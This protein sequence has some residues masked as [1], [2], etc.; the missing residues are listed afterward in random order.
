M[1]VVHFWRETF[2]FREPAVC[3]SVRH[4]HD[5]VPFQSV[6]SFLFLLFVRSR[7]RGP[8]TLFHAIRDRDDSPVIFGE[9]KD[10]SLSVSLSLS[11]SPF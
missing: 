10:E 9:R 5:C 6:C 11:L 3:L 4:T 2:F 1:E 7:A 8:L